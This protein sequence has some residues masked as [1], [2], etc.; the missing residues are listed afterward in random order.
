MQLIGHAAKNV[1]EYP[2]KKRE[3]ADEPKSL[4]SRRFFDIMKGC[5]RYEYDLTGIFRGKR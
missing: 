5:L 4:D 3:K 2:E 1:G